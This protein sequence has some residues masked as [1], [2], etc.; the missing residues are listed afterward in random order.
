[1][2]R[3]LTRRRLWG[4]IALVAGSLMLLGGVALLYLGLVP[5]PAAD[6]TSVPCPDIRVGCLL[7]GQAG[8]VVFDDIPQAMQPFNVRVEAHG[9]RTC[10]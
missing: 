7:P 2:G 9:R 10:M 4:W 5:R 8:R 3:D 1:M 6:V